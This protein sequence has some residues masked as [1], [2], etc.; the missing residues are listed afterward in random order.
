MLNVQVID[1]NGVLFRTFKAVRLT[2]KVASG[3][4]YAVISSMGRTHCY[5]LSEYTV[6][7]C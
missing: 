6:S 3:V 7:V 2:T 4:I 5:D 1:K